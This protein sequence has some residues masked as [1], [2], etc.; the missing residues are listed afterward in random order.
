MTQ[1]RH[2]NTFRIHM[3]EYNTLVIREYA[4]VNDISKHIVTDIYNIYFKL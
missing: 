4:E 1:W 2:K 3:C